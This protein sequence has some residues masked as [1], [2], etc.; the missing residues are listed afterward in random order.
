MGHMSREVKCSDALGNVVDDEKCTADIKPAAGKGCYGG[1]N[2]CR[3]LWQYM[4]WSEVS[5]Q[6]S[7]C[8]IR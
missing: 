7:D 4:P 3:L 8:I 2:H 1:G 5:I 6:Y